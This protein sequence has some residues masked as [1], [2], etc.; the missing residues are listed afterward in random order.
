MK[1][2]DVMVIG[3]WLAWTIMG[4]GKNLTSKHVLG[5]S[6]VN[7]DLQDLWNSDVIGI[8]DPA[9]SKNIGVKGRRNI[10]AVGN[11]S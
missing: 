8:T 9:E 5:L 4:H 6:S 11:N 1:L 3:T 10:Q 2:D 7:F